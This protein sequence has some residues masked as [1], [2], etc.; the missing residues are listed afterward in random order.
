M[1]RKI[2]LEAILRFFGEEG[3]MIRNRRDSLE[4]GITDDFHFLRL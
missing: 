1:F 3:G 4:G 2:I